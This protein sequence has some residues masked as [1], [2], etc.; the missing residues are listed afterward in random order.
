MSG[1]GGE[2][3]VFVHGFPMSNRV[4]DGQV[5]ALS[6]RCRCI[7]PD[8]RGFGASANHVE[9]LDLDHIADD[10]AALLRHEGADR[11]HIVGVSLGGMV[12]I[13]FAARYPELT[14]SLVVLHAD[15]APDDAEA[16]HR[17]NLQIASV[18]EHGVKAFVAEFASGLFPKGTNEKIIAKIRSIMGGTSQATVIAGLKLLRDRP[19]Q[20][21]Q[22]S[23][24]ECP[25][26]VI[27]GELDA[28]SPP[29]VL[30]EMASE[31]QNGQFLELEGAGHMS[32]M[33]MP[34]IVSNCLSD[35]ILRQ[36]TPDV[37]R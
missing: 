35:W 19:D 12:A 9:S 15:A 23:T 34:D 22:L 29:H 5:E 25:T 37:P 28:G 33:Q 32:I 3:I 26:L 10:I 11:A 14:K 17:R 4:W 18:L 16:I 21:G 27:A 13:R 6:K 2:T 24:I 8:L 20:T 30:R 1:R 31:F 7:V 36:A